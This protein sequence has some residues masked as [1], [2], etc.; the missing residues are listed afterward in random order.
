MK[1]KRM[2]AGASRKFVS[3]V[4][5]ATIV[6]TSAMPAAA[7]EQFFFRYKPTAVSWQPGENPEEDLKLG[8]G[9]DITIFFTGPIGFPFS[10]LIPV[11]TKDVVKWEVNTGS[12]HPG[13]SVD[14][15][16][17]VVSGTPT[18][19]SGTKN[20]VLLGYDISGR[21]IARATITSNFIDPAGQLQNFA[22]YGH[23]NKYMYKEIPATVPV[24]RW[25]SVG[26]LPEGFATQGR[27]LAG[28]PT[29]ELSTSVGFI[30]YDYMGKQVAFTYGDLI[31]QDKP[32]F[33]VIA[34]K[35]QHPSEAFRVSAQP[36]YRVGEMAYR[37]VALDGLPPSYNFQNRSGSLTATIPTFNTSMRFRIEGTDADGV[38]GS[39]N[40]FTF[41]TTSPD[42]AFGQMRDQEGTLHTAYSMQIK[43][44]D[45]SGTMNWTV[46]SGE[47][48]DGITLN[49]ETGELSGYPTRVETKNDIVIGV[50]TS[51]GGRGQT[52]AFSFTIYPQEIGVEFQALETRVGRP[53]E[54][55]T[56]IMGT[57]IVTPWSFKLAEGTT[58]EDTVD[59][60]FSR[61]VVAGSISTAG[62]HSV[63]FDFRNGDGRQATF[64]Q[65]ITVYD[66]LALQYEPEVKVY[67]RMPANVS[68]EATGVI[69]EALYRLA[70]GTLPEGLSI[71]ERTGA[72]VGTP[73]VL[74]TAVDLSVSVSDESGDQATSNDFE[75][76]VL[77]RPDVVVHAEGVTLERFVP[78]E[79]V[80]ATAENVFDGV[81]Y[82]LVA[83][84][85]PDGLELES[86]GIIRGN[87]TELVGVYEGLQIKATDGE[88]YSALSPVFS[89]TLVEPADL[90]PVGENETS[91]VFV[92]WTKNSEFTFDLPVPANAFG[93]VDY[94]V[95]NLPNGVSVVDGQL[96]G[97]I[98]EVGTYSVPFSLTD[99]A[100]RTLTGTFN[101][102]ILEP[103]SASIEG[104]GKAVDLD[105]DEITFSLPR[106][107]DTV[108]EAATVNAI[109]E[110]TYDFEGSLPSGL[111][112]ENGKIVGNPRTQG[113]VGAFTLSLTDAAG[114]RVD[115]PAKVV[116]VDRVPLTLSYNIPNPV[117]FKDRAIAPIIPTVQDAIGAVS[118]TL[119]GD[120]PAGIE[121]DPASGSFFGTPSVANWFRG[122]EVTAT[123]SEG[124]DYASTF[125]PFAMLVSLN[126]T[127]VMPSTTTFVVRAAEP[128]ERTL[129]VSNVLPPVAFDTVGGDPLAHG[130]ALDPVT[131]KISGTLAEP[132]KYVAG[133]VFA[134]DS[135]GREV[136]TT[137]NVVAVGPVAINTPPDSTFNQYLNVDVKPDAANIIGSAVFEL[138]GG[139]L[140]SFLTLDR[141][142]GRISGVAE[143]KGTYE[144]L[145]IKVTDSTGGSAVTEA[146][147]I[148]VGDRL[149]LELNTDESYTITANKLYRLSLPVANAVGQVTF[150]L[151]GDL[152]EGI[153]F[154]PAKGGFS[155]TAVKLG[156]YPITVT[157]TDSVG[158][159]VTKS[160]VL[161]SI[162][163]GKPINLSVRSFATVV[164][165]PIVTSV[166]T[167]SNHIGVVQY[168]A[169]ESLADYGLTIDPQ[170]GVISGTATQLMDFTPNIHISDE[171]QRVTSQP[172]NIKVVPDLVANVPARLEIVVNRSINP[173]IRVSADNAI[174][175]VVWDIE[176]DLP[177][178]MKFSKKNA[179]FSGKPTEMGTFP[180]K[181]I[182]AEEDGFARRATVD[183][184]IEVVT[185]GLAP[186]VSVTPDPIGYYV[187]SSFTIYPKYTNAK[188]GDVVTLAP[189]SAPLP[190]G[191]EI[192]YSGGKY[193]LRLPSGVKS[194]AGVYPG[195]KLKVTA[196][197][198]LS[199][200]SQPFTIIMKNNFAYPSVYVDVLAYQP[201]TIPVPAVANG[202]GGPIG[203]VKYTFSFT[204]S[205][206]VRDPVTIDPN[207]G[208]LTGHVT[209]TRGLYVRV[210]D[211]YEG[212]TLRSTVYYV[213]I[214]VKATSLKVNPATQVAF[215]DLSYP[216]YTTTLANGVQ[217]GVITLEG[218][219]PEG[220]TVDPVTGVISGVPTNAGTYPTE[221]VYTDE[222]QRIVTPFTIA[223]EQSAPVGK[224]YKFLK[225]D[226]ARS[227]HFGPMAFSSAS[228]LDITH[229]IPRRGTGLDEVFKRYINLTSGSHVFELPTYMPEGKVRA[230]LHDHN[231]NTVVYSASVDGQDW[232]EIGRYEGR[233]SAHDVPFKYQDDTA[234][235]LF[236]FNGNGFASG[237]TQ[238]SYNFD[239]RTLVDTSSLNGINANQLVWTWDLDP[240]RD[241]S[242]MDALPDGLSISGYNLRGT[243]TVAGKY[244]VVLTGSYG[245][246]QVSKA[247]ELD[248]EQLVASLEMQGAELPAGERWESSYDIDMTQ[249]LTA[250]GMPLSEVRFALVNS[251]NVPV[252]PGDK[253][254]SLPP[255]LV[256]NNATRKLTGT[257]TAVGKFRF[258]ISASWNSLST[259]AEFTMDFTGTPAEPKFTKLAA[260]QNHT[261]GITTSGKVSCWGHG[262]RGKLGNVTE[263]NMLVPTDVDGFPKDTT[264]V[265]IRAGN[266]QTCT[267][268]S[269]GAMMCWGGDGE[270]TGA[271]QWYATVSQTYASGTTDMALKGNHACFVVN[272]AVKCQGWNGDTMA[273][274]LSASTYWGGPNTPSG[275]SSGQKAVSVGAD[276]SCALSNAGAVK[277]WGLRTDGRLGNNT[278]NTTAVS[279][280]VNVTGLTSGVKSLKSG[281]AFSCA[282]TSANGV[283]CWGNNG[284]GQ[285]GNGNTTAQ[286]TPVDV[287]GLTS[288]VQEISVGWDHACALTNAGA[289]KC[290]GKNDQGQLGNGTKINSSVPVDVVG[291]S[292]VT[293]ITAGGGHTCALMSNGDHTCWGTNNYGQL[294]DGTNVAKLQP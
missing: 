73:E 257:P 251:R 279:S 151:T 199:G 69:G 150:T 61:L 136:T 207:T 54:T 214:K 234:A 241:G 78:N 47:L 145:V 190:E 278:S 14:S 177:V 272:G 35:F 271:S 41:K 172:I 67:R 58:L 210:S 95:L 161:V 239:L 196:A 60:D 253:A 294:G 219:A 228:G 183:V 243:P 159:S 99:D 156:S 141:S 169:D 10:K 140:P 206:S 50:V 212:K 2:G 153:Q 134:A 230:V 165:E 217:T 274:G 112:Y 32:T 82:E 29:Q 129:E 152:P 281:A 105:T 186:T 8:V 157:V 114:S 227:E 46:L 223:V 84:A 192:V 43:A 208:V 277:C 15:A 236:A 215:T 209:K 222:F 201:L 94:Q 91:D 9:N 245:D 144:G 203:E 106:G 173:N 22:F 132:N 285:I 259:Q 101:I 224:G 171:T 6:A 118:F 221:L 163:D 198:G 240:N 160:F 286:K 89:V 56:P 273:L 130:L 235:E 28:T 164:G 181:L 27:Y 195:I 184:E 108:I 189:D 39:T 117:G 238:M 216:S 30:G 276:F 289:V 11:R 126:G 284:Y 197:D 3:S 233:H 98:A 290:W 167:Y 218:L 193:V 263:T 147:S 182:V 18:G 81:S 109:G 204:N 76:E 36:Q 258:A 44:E 131:G 100:R 180:V 264:V 74:E 176:G 202:G 51:D 85:L 97:T 231:N 220:L 293:Q 7:S 17:G 77:D 121:F 42:V 19:K 226:L 179:M 120:L 292:G 90:T 88:G 194:V 262:S 275:L 48:P 16:N 250:V 20:S 63:A 244:A 291:L 142:T 242:A 123:D 125:G 57:G 154:D 110:V 146:F 213:G 168:W 247:F 229:L 252:Q 87:T 86:D 280:P 178:G 267:I 188:T 155:G 200:E 265:D 133:Q 135:A 103:M 62:D 93:S 80:A 111:K 138:V 162:T 1:S 185:D 24:A 122:L 237:T 287:S 283:K 83:G 266:N 256:F 70:S 40:V 124:E 191:M 33:D 143:A 72:I 269:T 71:D 107:G 38:V 246:K 149:P 119:K 92:Q 31:V 26:D 148:T 260:G 170:T 64:I 225:I 174:G 137:V 45:L 34:D 166:P 5:A 12:L 255:G 187:T 248:I 261:C 116:V 270:V 23:T 59:V 65:P 13:L 102:E 68:P 55:A 75:L 113:D 282:I 49:A 127:P 205:G 249:Y 25:E 79:I 268:T 158:A 104:R 4:V 288:G 66:P 232:V 175:S 96:V 21:L 37:L 139:S 115:L 53:F 52:P 128:F 211:T 254:S